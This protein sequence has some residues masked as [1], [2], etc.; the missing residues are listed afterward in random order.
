LL[1]SKDEGIDHEQT[2]RANYQTIAGIKAEV[3]RL[4]D[5][6]VSVT[7]AEDRAKRVERLAML[8][9]SLQ[10]ASLSLWSIVQTTNR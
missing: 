2:D 8:R 10:M 4:T 6:A 3:E 5:E 1:I 7:H 9:N